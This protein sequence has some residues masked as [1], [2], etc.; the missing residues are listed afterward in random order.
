M[1]VMIGA[2][3]RHYLAHQLAAV[4]L[5]VSSAD[6]AIDVGKRQA[7]AIKQQTTQHGCEDAASLLLLLNA[8]DC[9]L[10]NQ[11]KTIFQIC[12]PNLNC[13]CIVLSSQIL[14]HAIPP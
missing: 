8:V 2:V 3:V 12:P 5:S 9:W 7:C 10:K 13:T 4:Y 1:I 11:A 6:A 14:P